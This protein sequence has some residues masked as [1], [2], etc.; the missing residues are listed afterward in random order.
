M[1]GRLA[2]GATGVALGACGAWLLVSRSSWEQLRAVA[3]WLAAGVAVHDAVVAVVLLL[4]GW[5]VLRWVPVW[6]RGPLAI[7]AVVLGT[8]TV[9]AI[10]VLGGWGRR[11]DN[12]TLLDRDYLIGWLV[13]AGLV[14]AGVLVACVVVR[15]AMSGGGRDG[16]RSRG[17]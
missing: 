8:V 3:I 17:R 2:L 4:A 12:A 10:P 13:L 1:T 15:S 11:A 9:M 7:G 14:A 16:T 5:V 6:A